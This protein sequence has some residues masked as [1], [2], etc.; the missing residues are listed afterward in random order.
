MD[1][2]TLATIVLLGGFV[3][4]MFL[5]VPVTFALLLSTIGS[6]IVD[7]ALFSV[8]VGR[9]VKGANN[10]TLLSIPFFILMGEIMSAGGISEKIVDLANLFVGRLRGGLAY[11]NCIDSMFFG[12][13]SGSAVADVSSLGSIVVP[14]MVKQ[15]Y[16]PEFSVGLTVTTA[17]QGVLIPPSHNMVIYCLAAG[18]AVSIGKMFLAGAIPGIILG[19]ALMLLCFFFA[20]WYKFPRGNTIPKGRRLKVLINA[21]GPMMIFVIIMGGIAAGVFTATESAAVACVYTFIL[22]YFIFRTAKLRDFW[23]VCKNAL[24]TLAIVLTLIA[25]A[26]AFA[27]TMTSLYIPKIITDALLSL[28]SNKY[29][30]LLIIN[31]LLLILGCFM[32]M[33][34]LIMIM[35][36]ILLP[37]VT[38]PAI[39]MNPTHFGVVL[40]FNLA[41][42]LCTPPVGSALFVGCAVG[43]TSLEKTSIAMLPMF[44]IMVAVLMLIT[45]VPFFSL[46]LPGLM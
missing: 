11:V 33:A 4:L 27:Y 34:P 9:M 37:V 36:P 21:I 1:T 30:L 20:N 10:F 38:S 15:G 19:L 3:V 43:K 12:G 41:I 40:I 18:G 29:V 16:S 13:I 26:N 17:C 39:G 35:T 23:K 31:A 44:A 45:F 14:M 28:T 32:D 42:G 7:G 5:R 2:T 22:T 46:W 24:K 25:T 6:F 8:I